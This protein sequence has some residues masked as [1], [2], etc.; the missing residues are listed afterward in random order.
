[1]LQNG[2]QVLNIS[3]DRNQSLKGNPGMMVRKS[4]RPKTVDRI[5]EKVR[6]QW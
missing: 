2:L 4:Q 1:M 3:Q 6:Q 5:C